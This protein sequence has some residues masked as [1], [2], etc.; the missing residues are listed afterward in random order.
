MNRH[1]DLLT[2]ADLYGV[3]EGKT[4]G[5]LLKTLKSPVDWM[6]KFEEWA[7]NMQRAMVFLSG[8][9]KAL[10]RGM[11]EEEARMAGVELANKVLVDVN[12]LTP[13]ERSIAR[14][15]MPFYAFT[16]H[17]YKYV[18]SMPADHPIRMSILTNLAE[19]EVKDWQSG[20]PQTMMNLFAL[21]D[22]DSNGNLKAIDVRSTNPFRS[23]AMTTSLDGLMST[24]NPIITAPFAA[25][26]WNVL[27][28]SPELFPDTQINPQTGKLEAKPPSNAGIRFMS[29]FIPQVQ[30]L[31]DLIGISDQA[32]RM[33]QTDPQ[34]LKRFMLNNMGLGP[35]QPPTSFNIP[36][37][38]AKAEK[39]RY[40]QAQKDVSK[41]VQSGD[42]S[43]I[44]GYQTVPFQSQLTTPSAIGNILSSVS[45]QAQQLGVSPKLL[46]PAPRTPTSRLRKPRKPRK[47]RIGGHRTTVHKARV[48]KPKLGRS[49]RT[50]RRKSI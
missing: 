45:G 19:M 46:I 24:L 20:L 10:R 34:N 3:A 31:D 43:T 9:K 15:V 16:K 7:L 1:Q 12:G 27:T 11:T 39:V 21:G 40:Q 26:G 28:N 23:L 42:T 50:R 25:R 41:A 35:F 48:P 18:L 49:T 44:K 14:R 33:Q 8:E 37:E 38:M 17:L 32:R 29:A 47:P 13:I 6:Q 5:R 4:L 2:N 30:T 36:T 22:P